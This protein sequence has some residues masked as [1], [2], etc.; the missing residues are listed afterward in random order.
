M[1]ERRM[2]A[3]LLV[4]VRQFTMLLGSG[5][6]DDV[7]VS[8]V[9][10]HSNAGDLLQWLNSLDRRFDISSFGTQG[11]YVLEAREWLDGLDRQFNASCPEDYGTEGRGLCFLFAL[12]V[13][14]LSFELERLMQ[15]YDKQL[16]EAEQSE[17]G[18]EPPRSH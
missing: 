2:Y 6:H 1:V 3:A 5:R 4:L 16:A 14:Q 18:S 13:E 8:E 12:T 17:G 7:S 15:S 11:I 9:R 10:Q